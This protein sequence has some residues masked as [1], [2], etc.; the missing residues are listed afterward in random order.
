[1]GSQFDFVLQLAVQ[2]SLPNEEID[3]MVLSIMSELRKIPS[4][5]VDRTVGAPAP[6][7]AKG[8]TLSLGF[9]VLV[10]ISGGLATAAVPPVMQTVSNW[11]GRQPTGTKIVINHQGTMLEIS[12]SKP[13]NA[14]AIAPF[15]QHA[16]SEK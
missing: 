11:L 14:E 5:A 2:A 1:M 3:R 16:L 9:Q 10:A 12:G 7:G 15:I 4:L 6:L 13:V 8:D